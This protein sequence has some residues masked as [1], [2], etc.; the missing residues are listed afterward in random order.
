MIRR[1]FMHDISGQNLLKEITDYRKGLAVKKIRPVCIEEKV[2][3]IFNGRHVASL[4]VSPGE[5]D[6][7][8]AGFVITQGL[9]SKV[10]SVRV[11]NKNIIVDGLETGKNVAP[12]IESSGGLVPLSN[13]RTII[14][15]ITISTADIF[16]IIASIV[17]DL[18]AK[19]GG[20]HCSVLY[21][22]DTIIAKS[23][24]VGRHNTVDK[25]VGRAVLNGIT[26]NE[27]ILGCTGRQPEGMIAKALNA[28]IP[29]IVTK[30]ATTDKGAELA[31]KSGITLIARVKDESFEVYSRAERI[32]G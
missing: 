10:E 32:I 31:E 17:S 14:S 21:L 26:L 29:I 7:L 2:S 30:S 1:Y 19:T 24:D 11:E 3:I 27:C 12:V 8:G 16:K 6:E 25:V 4:I 9:C 22:K 13:N 5:Y 20:A 15:D 18:W 28:G 23:S